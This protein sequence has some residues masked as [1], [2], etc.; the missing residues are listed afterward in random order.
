MKLH[1]LRP[2]EGAKK[3]RK[4]VGRGTG[5]GRG[6]TSTRGTK[7]QNARS[8]GGVRPTF[9]GGQLPLVKR[10]P[11][12]RG[13]N[14]RFK[15]HYAAINVDV[16]DRLFEA[17]DQVS[18]DSLA[19]RGLIDR[20]DPIVIL[21]RGEIGKPVHVKAHRVSESARQKIEAAGGSIELLPVFVNKNL[22][23]S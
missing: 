2:A 23:R 19:D 7:G 8:G 4:R 3:K 20:G 22:P 21:G 1:D 10:L 5:S 17:N 11:K 12:L 18:P 13:F 14:N 6:K 15:V 9:E 16:L